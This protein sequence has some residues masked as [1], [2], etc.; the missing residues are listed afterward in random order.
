MSP[1]SPGLHSQRLSTPSH[2]GEIGNVPFAAV[3]PA[4]SPRISDE[5]GRRRVPRE[6]LLCGDS[7]V[8]GHLPLPD[9]VAS[10]LWKKE[11]LTIGKW[12]EEASVW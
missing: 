2:A 9:V 6:L 3:Q 5:E 1:H 8:V 10:I 11:I 4:I 7:L 12:M